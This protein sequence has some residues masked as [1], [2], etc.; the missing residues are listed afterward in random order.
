[1]TTQNQFDP[2]ESVKAR[3]RASLLAALRVGPLTTLEAREVLGV[4]HP[5]GRVLEL[6]RLGYAIVTLRRK[7]VDA[8]GRAHQSAAYVLRDGGAA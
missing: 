3:Q 2:S 5:A 8:D 4:M 7:V 1:M 6:R